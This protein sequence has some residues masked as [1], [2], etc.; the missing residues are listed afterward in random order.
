M[1]RSSKS[2]A[3]LA[4][5][6]AKA[7]AEL[8]NPEKSLTATIRSGRPG[9]GER[10]FR[11]APLASG[12][13]I[14]RKTLGQHE[15]A[16]MQTTAIDQAVG[17]V[18]LTT[19]LAHASGEWIASDWPVCP[20]ADT[21]NP[22]RMGAALT[23]ARRYA[24]FTL[25]GIAGEDD[26]D[27]P[28]LSSPAPTVGAT[29][30]AV[31]VRTA[32]RHGNG[33]AAG[34]PKPARPPVLHP[35]ESAALRNRLLN[36]IAGL[37][38]QDAATKWAKEALATKN[39]LVADDAKLLEDA[40]EQRVSG[41]EP[42]TVDVP[43][44]SASLVTSSG[45]E[46]T[47]AAS[48]APSADGEG[49]LAGPEIARADGAEIASAGKKATRAQALRKRVRTGRVDKSVLALSEP[50]RHR[51]RDHLRYVAQQACVVCGRKPSDPHHLRY[52]QPRALGR[53][54]SDEFTVPLCRVHHRELHRTA[55]ERAWWKRIAIDPITMARKLWTHTLVAQG[56]RPPDRM[57]RIA[58]YRNIGYARPFRRAWFGIAAAVML[59]NAQVRGELFHTPAGEAFVD[60]LI[61]GHRH[62]WAVRGKRFRTWLRRRYYDAIGD[63]PAAEAIRSAL[64]LLEARAQ[65]D[66]PE[67]EVHLRVAELDGCI[68]LDLANDHWDAVEIG[69]AGWRMVAY[70]PVRFRRPPGMLPL[71][72]PVHG[73]SIQALAAFLNVSSPN[74][75]VMVVA[76][77]LAALRSRGP[78]PLLAISGEQGTA[79]T[80]LSKMLRALIDPNAAPVRSLAREERELMIAAN[81]SHLLAFDNIS[82]F[83]AWLSDALC[84]LATGGSLAIRRLYT[85]SEE[86]LFQ[87]ERPILLNGI[88]DVVARPDLADRT[89][90][91]TLPPVAEGHRR[92]ETELWREFELAR[93]RILGALLDAAVH[94]LQRLSAVRLERLPRMADFA[95]WA[96]ACET[97]FWPS[98]TFMRAYE[99]NRR[100]AIAGVIDADP[101][102]ACIREI[103]AA[104]SAWAGTA[105]G[106][107]ASC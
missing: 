22:Q 15:I 86:V 96:S 4:A 101:V 77:L 98:G 6:L 1:P 70:P 58:R 90:F 94:G 23:Y 20:I 40:F 73:G 34:P 92:S 72:V 54:A 87:A 38:S 63:V 91:L 78:Y 9:E 30:A 18:S 19:M 26:L 79:K 56:Q 33:R 105:G 10:S 14:V 39:R 106:A 44:T 45:G 100:A 24:L 69:P 82:S 21:A 88:E 66:A 59:I 49:D 5:A 93:P 83:P 13:D 7:Q 51:N 60:L 31:A 76:W 29:G 2:V 75:L 50:R 57:P 55:N 42:G 71:P 102:A 65:F 16:T 17:M 85:D 47:P 36:E 64:D 61:S 53:K 95:I 107:S 84:R 41:L 11:Y 81:N 68:Y 3:A 89:I 35:H 74:D 80:M 52:M 25:V 43:G 37:E 67:R 28:D 12:L 62:T 48:H 46:E 32:G 104:R 97:A 99:A 103:M 27:A 8:I